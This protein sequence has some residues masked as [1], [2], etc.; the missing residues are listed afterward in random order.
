[1]NW[2]RAFTSWIFGSGPVR[3]QGYQLP[4]P[5]VYD[6]SASPPVGFDSA[7]QLSAVWACV[8]LLAETVASLPLGVYRVTPTGRTVATDH[9]LHA[10]FSGMVNRYQNRIEFFETVIL[11][12][13]VTG[14]AYVAIERLNGRITSLMPL[15]SAQMQTRLMPDGSI[16]YEYTN[17]ASVRV[18]A[19]SSVWHLKLMGNGIVG[20]SVLD[21][22]RDT[23]N[24][25]RGAESSVRKVYANGGKPSGVLMID[26]VL[27]P[28]QREMVRAN[29]NGLTEGD[30]QRLFVLEAGA[31]YEQVSLSPQ[32]I[33]LLASRG[34]NIEEICRWYGVPSVMVNHTSGTTWGSGIQTIIEGFY[35]LT[36]RPILEKVELSAMVKLLAPAERGE[37]EIEFDFDALLRADLKARMDAYA[38][39]INNGVLKPAEARVLE[40][41]PPADGADQLLVQGAMVPLT[42]AGALSRPEAAPKS[43]PRSFQVKRDADG[44]AIVT[45]TE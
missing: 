21:Y 45:P 42:M 11:N 27:T 37:I 38:V 31:K 36:M 1:M 18:Y 12:L 8:K 35:K 7:M 16:V 24:I 6:T 25:A 22:Q 41:L 43:K 4:G 26:R 20:L 23:L 29:F 28:E 5:G 32:D 30:S 17:E 33:E 10:L 9:P 34:F 2:F 19:S 15:M 14:N 13:V 3:Y 39:G 44:N 40:G